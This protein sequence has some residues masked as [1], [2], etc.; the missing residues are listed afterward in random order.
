[1]GDAITQIGDE[2][3]EGQTAKARMASKVAQLAEH[4]V[5]VSDEV[6]IAP[7]LAGHYAHEP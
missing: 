7:F 6:E 3:R 1:M 2:A 4:G 5:R